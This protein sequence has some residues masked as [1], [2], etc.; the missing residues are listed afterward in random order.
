MNGQ[1][2]ER[3][4]QVEFKGERTDYF[5]NAKN[6]PVEIGDY[7]I[8]QVERGRDMGKIIRSGPDLE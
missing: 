1:N 7:V 2:S 6:L 5:V 3:I 4:V 8:V